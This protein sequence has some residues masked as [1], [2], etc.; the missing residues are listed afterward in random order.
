MRYTKLSRYW[1]IT[2]S[3]T[4]LIVPLAMANTAFSQPPNPRSEVIDNRS[5]TNEQTSD[6]SL[7]DQAEGVEYLTRGPLH[8][9]FAEPYDA[10]PEP[11]PVVQQQPPEPIDEMPPEY[12]PDGKNVTWIPGYWSWDDEREDFIWVSGVWRDLPPGQQWVP[13]Y[14]D[15]ANDGYRYIGG[16]WTS[17]DVSEVQYLPEPPKSL[18]QG[19]SSPAPGEDHFYVPG[20]WVYENNDYQWQPGFWSAAHADWVWVP[21]QYVWT[22]RGCVYQAGYWDHDVAHRGVLFTPVYYSQPVYRN[23]GYSYRPRYTIDTSVGLFVHLFV[24]PSH[25]HYYFGDYYGSR[26]SNNYYPWATRYQGYQYYDP[27]YASFHNR[28]G[29]G[30][31]NNLLGWITNQYQVFAR[32]D[33]YRP[34]R[35]IADQRNFLRS[36]QNTEIDSTV[37]RLTSLGESLDVLANNQNSD[38]NLRRIDNNEIDRI[39][40]SLDPLR[41]LSR[42]RLNLEGSSANADASVNTDANVDGNNSNANAQANADA[43]G[44]LRL[45]GRDRDESSAAS[46]LSNAANDLLGGGNSDTP[47]QQNDAERNQQGNTAMDRARET[48]N[49][50]ANTAQDRA[51]NASEQARDAAGQTRDAAEQARN[52]AEGVRDRVEGARDTAEAARETNGRTRD[53]AEA[54]REMSERARDRVEGARDRVE[55]ARDRAEGARDNIEGAGE[56]SEP[57]RDRIEQGRDAANREARDTAESIRERMD[58]ATDGTGA[59]DRVRDE[60]RRRSDEATRQTERLEALRPQR[61]ENW[62]SQLRRSTDRAIPERP[63]LDNSR[64]NRP[65]N[66]PGNVPGNVPN[67]GPNNVPGNLRGNTPNNVPGNLPGNLRGNV[68]GNI[69]GNAPGNL[70]PN[71]GG[72]ANP[73][74]ALRN[75]T[76]SAAPAIQQGINNATQGATGGGNAVQDVLNGV[77]G[78]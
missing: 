52:T 13:G 22:P 49:N 51:R 10:N 40:Q 65:N 31:S 25:R 24:R 69:P 29:R 1:R 39:R 58:R 55:G 16:F 54:A 78:G 76:E 26:Y 17:N 53:T 71:R 6:R 61:P 74:R 73:G 70:L 48:A 33:R 18:E 60:L 37:L 47:S 23:A 27:F 44:S 4:G 2:A 41:E 30:G 77:I 68:P 19:P 45:P 75:A 36:N 9:A 8:E 11:S 62:P 15:R 38:L 5:T 57:T 64:G 35:T 14:W 67:N 20:N 12:R 42:D 7:D 32:N 46:D 56:M 72:N 59:G 43:R 28:N 3:A 66:V 21:A 63:R 34:A 50:A